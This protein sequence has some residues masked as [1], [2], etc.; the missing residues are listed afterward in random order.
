MVQPEAPSRPVCRGLAG[1]KLLAH[2]LV[3]KADDHLLFYR[4][5]E[6]FAR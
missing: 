4:Q 2:I 6:I 5:N 1:P 3:W